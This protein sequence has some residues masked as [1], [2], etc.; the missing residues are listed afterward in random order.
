M[1]RIGLCLVLFFSVFFSDGIAQNSEVRKLNSFDEIR[2]SEAITVYLKEGN[3]EELRLE[4]SGIDLDQVITEVHG[5]RLKIHLEDGR[6]RSHSVKVYVTYKT[7]ESI[8]ASSASNVFSE[9]VIKG[10]RLDIAVSSAADVEV[11]VEVD[12]VEISV[13]SS[14]DLDISGKAKNIEIS[15]SSAGGVDAYDLDARRVYVRASSGGSAKVSVK[16]EI[17]ARAS[18]GGSVRYK[19]NPAKSKTDSSSGGSV[20]K[21]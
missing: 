18:S 11:D 17:D 1:N 10:Q 12:E 16:E 9:S 15:V 13:S 5:S 19:G 4:V 2:V 20:R 21:S 3:T 8:S 7:L 14:G 6:F